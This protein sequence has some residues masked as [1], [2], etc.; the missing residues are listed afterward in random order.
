MSS[1]DR[2]W[3]LMTGHGSCEHEMGQ[4]V[5][6]YATRCVC[7]FSVTYIVCARLSA[8]TDL[9]GIAVMTVR[10]RYHSMGIASDAP[11]RQM[12]LRALPYSPVHLYNTNVDIAVP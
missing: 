2:S 6:G 12:S 10:H 3:K 5:S 1:D 9:Q 4:A 8:K 11:R 7:P